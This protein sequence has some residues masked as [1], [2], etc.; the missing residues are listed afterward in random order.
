MGWHLAALTASAMEEDNL[1]AVVRGV[2]DKAEQV[3]R[4][5]AVLEQD[6]MNPCVQGW[7]SAHGPPCTCALRMVVR[8]MWHRTGELVLCCVAAP[9]SSRSSVLSRAVSLQACKRSWRQSWS[10]TQP[11]PR[12]ASTRTSVRQWQALC[13]SVYVRHVATGRMIDDDGA[14]SAVPE[15]LRSRL[16]PTVEARD[17]AADAAFKA[18]AGL[19]P[20][21]GNDTLGQYLPELKV[22]LVLPC[23]C[24]SSCRAGGDQTPHQRAP[25]GWAWRLV[26]ACR[27]VAR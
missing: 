18:E 17:E 24:A 6:H 26:A 15:L 12:T 14:Y 27:T 19:P 16:D 4:S 13:I 7:S 3:Q 9:T 10:T 8:H 20:D 25:C 21:A 2:K 1:T 5:I 22:C 11:A 23:E